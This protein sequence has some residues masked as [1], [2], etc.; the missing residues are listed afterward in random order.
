[1]MARFRAMPSAVPGNEASDVGQIADAVGPQVRGGGEPPTRS[2]MPP[3][4]PDI[5]SER[6]ASLDGVLIRGVDRRYMAAALE[7]AR[8]L[9]CRTVPCAAETDRDSVRGVARYLAVEAARVDGFNYKAALRR[10]NV[11]RYLNAVSIRLKPKSARHIQ[12]QLY[13]VGR[14]IHP[15]EYPTRRTLTSSNYRRTEAASPD[16]VAGW[17]AL[18][19]TLPTVLSRRVFTLLDL[20]YGAGVRAAEFKDLRGTSIGQTIWAGE[21]VA[22][23]R[24]PNRA[25]GTRTVPLADPE[26]SRRLIA[27]AAQRGPGHLIIDGEGEVDRNAVNK[28]S[29]YLK[30]RGHQPI[31]AAALRHRWLLNL[32]ETVPAVLMMQLAD[33]SDTRP[34]ADQRHLLPTFGVEHAVAWIKDTQR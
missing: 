30:R 11:D 26:A 17:Y 25:G 20:C 2:L 32:A 8:R 18:A 21:P 1:M 7:S 4:H 31:S 34:V 9:W 3:I 12:S 28:I 10:A 15:R 13:D 22:L 27:L 24:L 19:P 14:L 5:D 29:E 16:E 33:I 23:V 6:Y